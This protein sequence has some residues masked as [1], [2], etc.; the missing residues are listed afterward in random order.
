MKY[1][2]LIAISLCFIQCGNEDNKGNEFIEIDIKTV[3]FDSI[4]KSTFQLDERIFFIVMITNLSIDKHLVWDL[5][6][7]NWN[8]F[9]IRKDGDTYEWPGHF[10]RVCLL[11]GWFPLE[12][13]PSA[14]VEFEMTGRGDCLNPILL[15]E[16]PPE[17]AYSIMHSGDYIFT[18]KGGTQP[19]EVSAKITKDFEVR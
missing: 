17:G 15:S 10:T 2:I 4:Q 19:F 13:E 8:H 6:D 9:T 3:G 16:F 1:L 7:G 18:Y 12:L 5:P 11:R 14:T